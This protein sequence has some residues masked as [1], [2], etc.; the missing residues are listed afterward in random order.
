MNA[1]MRTAMAVEITPSPRSPTMRPLRLLTC[2]TSIWISI[3]V[4][5][6]MLIVMLPLAEKRSSVGQSP[7]RVSASMKGTPI[8]STPGTSAATVTG[9]Q[10]C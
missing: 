7:N 10:T 5:C 3:Q 2:V 9:I 1:V 8:N 4:N 6:V